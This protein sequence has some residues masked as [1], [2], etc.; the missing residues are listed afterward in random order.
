MISKKYI[1]AFAAMSAGLIL[2]LA[3]PALA[4]SNSGNSP[5]D[6]GKHFGFGQGQAKMGQLQGQ[7]PGVFGTV[8]AVSGNIITV[9][10]KQ[11]PNTTT[12]TTYTVDATNATITKDNAA[13][14][15]AS[16]VVGDTISAQGTLTG[17]N[18]VA[19]AIRDGQMMNR[20]QGIAGTVATISGNSLTVTGKPGFGSATSTATTYTVDATNAKITKTGV[21]SAT[22]ADIAVGDTVFIQGT[23][24]GTSVTA[25][26]IRDGQMTGRPG[27]ARGTPSSQTTQNL[28]ITGN[29][30]PVVA[31]TVASIG[32][33]SITITNKSNVTYTIDTTNAKITQGANSIT[34]AGLKTGDPV[35]VQGTVNGQNIAAITIIDQAKPAGSTTGA[36][37]GNHLGF[38]G[39]LGQL[40]MHLFG[41]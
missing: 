3:L 11:G 31:G 2:S 30:Q 37:Q 21:T 23:V 27:F 22:V 12:A 14:T 29:G 8:S 15:I 33:N 16:I 1:G 26:A 40:F 9:T 34:L 13:G 5:Q 17:T 28:A 6:A 24:S 20:G 19:T 38:L 18:L 10:G 36:N 41:F 39:G 32:T 4:A 35:V 25:T 7:R